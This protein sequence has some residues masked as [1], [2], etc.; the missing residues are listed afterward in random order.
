MKKVQK[1]SYQVAPNEQVTI[2]ITPSINLGNQYAAVLDQTDLERPENGVYT[3][4]VTKPVG[5]IHFFAIEFGFLAAPAGAQYRLDIN[6]NSA[7]NE[8]PFTVL[9]INGDPLLAKQFKFEVAQ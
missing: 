5:Q 7:N 9:V 4:P 1:Y 8:G 2:Q 6:G 3:F